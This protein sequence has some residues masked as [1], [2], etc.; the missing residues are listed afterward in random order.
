VYFGILSQTI[1]SLRTCQIP[2]DYTE[3]VILRRREVEGSSDGNH[4]DDFSFLGGYS[5][6][7]VCPLLFM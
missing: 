1:P 4:D 2:S 3:K 5:V 7:V 6:C